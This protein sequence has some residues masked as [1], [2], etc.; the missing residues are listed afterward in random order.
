MNKTAVNKT[1]LSFFGTSLDEIQRANLA[2]EE[3]LL[4]TPQDAEIRIE[5]DRTVLNFCANNY[6]GLANHPEIIAAAHRGLDEY[7]FGLA[8]GRFICG[9]QTIHKQLEAKIS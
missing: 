8:S 1:A 5:G 7:G 6:L 2:K 3:R 4:T 9:T